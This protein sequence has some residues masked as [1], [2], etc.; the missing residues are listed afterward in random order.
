MDIILF[1]ELFCSIELLLLLGYRF[2]LFQL[3]IISGTKRVLCVWI[4]FELKLLQTYFKNIMLSIHVIKII[5]YMKFNIL[6]ENHRNTVNL[7]ILEPLWKKK[8][9]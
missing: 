3:T 2:I 9:S 8:Y 1:H 6:Y 4:T 7:A 5:F